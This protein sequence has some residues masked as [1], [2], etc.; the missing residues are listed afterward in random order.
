FG[1]K[2]MLEKGLLPAKAT[3]RAF[4]SA[5]RVA[6]APMAFK[7]VRRETLRDMEASTGV[8]DYVTSSP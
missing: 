8:V 2:A 7:A 1:S 6:M 3:D 5:R 4:G